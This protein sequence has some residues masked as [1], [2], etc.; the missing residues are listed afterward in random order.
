MF[1]CLQRV[2]ALRAQVCDGDHSR[3]LDCISVPHGKLADDV[4]GECGGLATSCVGCD[5][6]PALD[7]N[8][9]ARYDACERCNGT[10]STCSI[11]LLAFNAAPRAGP[12]PAALLFL[13][14]LAAL[15][16]ILPAEIAA[17]GGD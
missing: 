8:L 10:N 7:P 3:C 9:R 12:P 11:L 17:A 16:A 2:C 1:V 5:G 4:C 13:A 14:A 15:A 6:Q